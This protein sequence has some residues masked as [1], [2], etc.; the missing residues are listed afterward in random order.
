MFAISL[1]ISIIISEALTKTRHFILKTNTDNTYQPYDTH[2]ILPI[3][4]HIHADTK[5]WF[6]KFTCN[7]GMGYLYHM[8][9][10]RTCA[11]L[12]QDFLSEVEISGLHFHINCRFWVRMFFSNFLKFWGTVSYISVD[13]RGI[14]DVLDHFGRNCSF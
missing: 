4:S 10:Y 6:I 11:S 8:L 13:F 9:R 2:N 7:P 3:G 5:H 14:P 12:G 1:K